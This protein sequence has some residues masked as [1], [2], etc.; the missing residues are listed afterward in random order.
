MQKEPLSKLSKELHSELIRAG[1]AKARV[2]GRVGGRRTTY[3]DTL[4]REAIHRHDS[5]ETWAAVADALGISLD[6]LYA[7]VRQ[8]KRSAMQHAD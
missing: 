8:L 3:P 5:G 7:R 1:Q 6:R 2:A 4:I